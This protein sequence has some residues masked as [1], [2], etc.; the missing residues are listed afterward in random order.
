MRRTCSMH[1]RDEKL[2]YSM[3]QNIISKADC[4]SAY[5]K[6]SEMHTNFYRNTWRQITR[7]TRRGRW[8]DNIKMDL[9]EIE[10]EDVD[11]KHLAQDRY[12]RRALVKTVMNPR[13]LKGWRISWL[14]DCYI[15]NK[16]CAPWSQFDNPTKHNSF[17]FI[18]QPIL[19]K[20]F[21]CLLLLQ[22]CFVKTYRF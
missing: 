14:N 19:P 3:V 12:Q 10:W 9:R 13:F 6:I 22:T 18:F 11:C 15:L 5:Q 1:G 8:E 4:H 2:T 7:T 21:T 16:V 17:S 20:S